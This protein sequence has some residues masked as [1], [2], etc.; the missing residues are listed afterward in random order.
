L[1]KQIIIIYSIIYLAGQNWV[2]TV[3]PLYVDF[4]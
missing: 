2:L 1:K 4:A 3:A